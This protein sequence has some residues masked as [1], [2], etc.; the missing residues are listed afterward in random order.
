M[1]LWK[2]K[3]KDAD[4]LLTLRTVGNKSNFEW[5]AKPWRN[6]PAKNINNRTEKRRESK[7]KKTKGVEWRFVPKS[8]RTLTVACWNVEYIKCQQVPSSCFNLLV[9]LF[10][11]FFFLLS[12]LH[13]ISTQLPVRIEEGG[14]SRAAGQ[15]A[16]SSTL[17]EQEAMQILDGSL[18]PWAAPTCT[19]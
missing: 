18:N 17:C 9:L 8:S 12:L 3:K 19:V 7:S 11:F 2:E 14:D 16:H 4:E 6:H 10:C 1:R 15:C 13:S 5:K